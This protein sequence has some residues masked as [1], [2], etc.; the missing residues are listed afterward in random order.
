MRE[1]RHDESGKMPPPHIC[2]IFLG[3]E[4]FDDYASAFVQ[5]GLE[6]GERVVWLH[7]GFAHERVIALLRYRGIDVE[8][9]EAQDA[10]AFLPAPGSFAPD[11]RFDLL[12]ALDLV[13]SEASR[14]RES[15][16]AG[17]RIVQELGPTLG[18][19]ANPDLLLKYEERLNPLL[20]ELGN[21]R[22]LC[23]YD[24]RS[25]P[26]EA[27]L[28]SLEAHPHVVHQ[29]QAVENMYFLP[30][31]R[32]SRTTP[33]EKLDSRITMIDGFVRG[34][35]AR[36]MNRALVRLLQV[37]H[38]AAEVASTTE[39][40]LRMLLD[41]LCRHTGWPVGHVYLR[42]EPDAE[43]TSSGIW[44]TAG[45]G[46]VQAF[47]S[48]SE[49]TRFEWGHG[50]PGQAWAARKPVWMR[51]ASNDPDFARGEA[52]VKAGIQAALA[53]P[54]TAKGSVVAV[55]EL[56]K[57]EPG[58][59]DEHLLTVME[60]L[61][62]QLG[63][64]VRDVTQEQEVES[65][66]RLLE[67]AVQNLREGVMVTTG[68]WRG[69]GPTILYV[70]PGFTA[71][72]GYAEAEVLGRGI[73]RILGPKTDDRIL[74][75]LRRSLEAGDSGSVELVAYG[76]DGTEFLMHWQA[77]PVHSPA[78]ELTHVVSIQ[79]D[80]TNERMAEQALHQAERDALTGLA[81]R[82]LLVRR[83]GRAVERAASNPTYQYALLFLDL[84]GFKAVNDS[85]GH[86]LGD[87][88]LA[89]A[90]RRVERT[91]RP[92]DTVAR[93]GGDEFVVLVEHVGDVAD[94]LMVTER[95][96]SALEL[97]FELDETTVRISASIGIALSHPTYEEPEEVLEDADSAMYRAKENGG[98]RFEFFDTH[99]HEQAVT[100]F[101]L[102]SDLRTAAEEGAFR[103]T[104][105][106]LVALDSGRIVGFEALVRW[107]HPERGTIA[108]N[109][110][111]P[112][113]EQGD[114]IR[115]IDDWVLGESCRQLGRWQ[116]LIESEEPLVMSVNVSPR[117]LR[118][119]DFADRVRS[120]IEGAKIDGSHLQIEITENAFIESQEKV[121]SQLEKVSAMGVRVCL[122]DFGTGY[123][124]LGYLQRFPVR[125]LKIDRAFIAR[126]SHSNGT[127]E[128]IRT[129]LSLGENLGIE[130]LAEGVETRDQLFALRRLSCQYG[131]GFLFSRP[132]PGSEVETLVSGNGSGN[133]NGGTF[134]V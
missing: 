4:A 128:I 52:A 24:R 42:T 79:R 118:Y 95:I 97:P 73:R 121:R 94:V 30:P 56:F 61:G 117:E 111:I 134:T 92:G 53:T 113:A 86:L 3:S 77:T 107:E 74:E 105:Q 91:V 98:G 64:M 75:R 115:T 60:H 19:E 108:P 47:V 63:S 76:K 18:S 54:V 70:N 85:L 72:T 2:G 50:L 104:Y 82:Q 1:R 126:M 116:N 93:F 122:D 38:R 41:E 129:I 10:L 100:T 43:L 99:T 67:S 14:A 29:G 130:V 21:C 57:F 8:R 5:D 26:D 103:L 62:G 34:Q 7:D 90:S 35:A 80:I 68:T 133:G 131:Q 83:L 49:E 48:A 32:D 39:D 123:S 101:Q 25:A 112:L 40:A 55:L 20:A 124:S 59:P 96:R 71:M 31:S 66:L 119:P 102:K 127:G 120:A 28:R 51:D 13:R 6:R 16:L 106:P 114:L 22:M 69:T 15:G 45:S 132:I 84:D 17:V 27:V 88:L 23:G 81:N 58:E 9:Y 37:V 33:T 12:T 44:H 46:Q 87:H 11:G 109:H 36:R 78:G 65:E 125:F 89:A 110:F